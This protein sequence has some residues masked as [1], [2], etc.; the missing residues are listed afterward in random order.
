MRHY[1]C[2]REFFPEFVDQLKCF[3]AESVDSR[4]TVFLLSGVDA[5]NQA[6]EPDALF[7][8]RVS[9]GLVVV[10]VAPKRSRVRFVGQ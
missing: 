2:E 9:A 7:P 10:R 1:S 5:I 6:P 4:V 3:P 8:F